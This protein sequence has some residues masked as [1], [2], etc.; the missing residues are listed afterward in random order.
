MVRRVYLEV[1]SA[2]RAE[3]VGRRFDLEPGTWRV[4]GRTLSEMDATM[5]M[6][7]DGDRALDSHRQQ[8]V[9]QRVGGP[10]RVRTGA[11]RGPDVDLADGGVSRTHAMVFR[12]AKGAASVVDLMST[13]GT[14]VNNQTVLDQDLMV[15]DDVQVGGTTLRYS[16][17]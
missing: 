16:V 9:D 6:T 2:P 17:V 12:D 3:E 5:P 10:A 15:G 7:R 13:N 8:M 11:R 1:T 14:R 4:L